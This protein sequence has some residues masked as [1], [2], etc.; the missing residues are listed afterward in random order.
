M[1][2]EAAILLP[3]VGLWGGVTWV[4]LRRHPGRSFGRGALIGL[5]TML[6]LLPA[7]LAHP[8]AHVA[9][10][11]LAGAPMDEVWISAG[12]PRTLDRTNAVSPAAPRLRAIGGQSSTCWAC[13]SARRSAASPTRF[14][15]SRARRLVGALR[16]FR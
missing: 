2:V 14:P 6:V 10:A 13:S 9:S 12:M 1:Q 4:G 16:H 15:R 8:F 7:D 11:R 5:T 3:L